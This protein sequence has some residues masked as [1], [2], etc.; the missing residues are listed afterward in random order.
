M[1]SYTSLDR[2]GPI[3]DHELLSQNN[4]N[5]IIYL[6]DHTRDLNTLFHVFPDLHKSLTISDLYQN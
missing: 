5:L 2:S 1:R 6:C 3:I 4:L